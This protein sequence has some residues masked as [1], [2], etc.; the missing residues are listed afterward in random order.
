VLDVPLQPVELK[1][2][3][4]VNPATC[5]RRSTNMESC[6]WHR[7]GRRSADRDILTLNLGEMYDALNKD[8]SASDPAAVLPTTIPTVTSTSQVNP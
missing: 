8:T 2:G 4:L 5:L 3:F 6:T 7:A 1:P